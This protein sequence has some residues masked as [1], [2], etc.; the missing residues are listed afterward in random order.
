[1]NTFEC[2]KT[3]RSIR[4]YTQQP[5]EFDKIAQ[6]IEAGIHAP[7]AGNMQNWRFIVVTEKNLLK[8]IYQ[9]CLHQEAVYNA[10]IAIIVCGVTDKAEMLYGL[11]GKRLYTVQNCACA[12]QNMLLAAN[13]LGLGACWIGAF[14]EDKISTVFG[15]PDNA[16]PQAI[17][18]LGYPDEKPVSDRKNLESVTYFNRYKMKIKDLH[19]LFKDYSVHWE[20][21]AEKVQEVSERGLKRVHKRLKEAWKKTKEHPKVRRFFKK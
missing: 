14:D 13:E 12:I 9:H 16:R 17:I 18:T 20:K 4:K 11:R 6:I 3:R 10:Q 1:M 15:I 21:Q 8:E 7:S 2:I 19:L 5:V